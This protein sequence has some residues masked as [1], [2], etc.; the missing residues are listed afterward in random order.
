MEPSRLR[1][2]PLHEARDFW[3]REQP[4]HRVPFALELLLAEDRV[5]LLV[6]RPAKPDRPPHGLSREV[7]LVPAVCVASSRHE[8]MAGERFVASAKCAAHRQ[9]LP[10]R[11]RLC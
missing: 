2:N 5:H 7:A 4:L 3:M 11:A 9:N 10:C 1:A 8:V 6:A